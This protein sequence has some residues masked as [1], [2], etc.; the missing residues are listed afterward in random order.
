VHCEGDPYALFVVK[1]SWQYPER[2]DEGGLLCEATSKG[3]IRVA[4]H[5]YYETVRVRDVDDDI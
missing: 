5:Y 4:R 1:D 2:N 3:A